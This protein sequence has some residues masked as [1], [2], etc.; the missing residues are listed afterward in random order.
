M[1]KSIAVD[2]AAGTYHCIMNIGG[3][4][5]GEEKKAYMREV[6][7]RHEEEEKHIRRCLGDEMGWDGMGWDVE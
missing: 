6:V 7:N 5:P 4:H 1:I 2:I 3:P